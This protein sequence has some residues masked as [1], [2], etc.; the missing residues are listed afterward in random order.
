MW[1][2]DDEQSM[3]AVADATTMG[4]GVVFVTAVEGTYHIEI[5]LNNVEVD[6]SFVT[7]TK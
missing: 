7:T 6:Q 1:G 4:A 2:I 5:T 3:T